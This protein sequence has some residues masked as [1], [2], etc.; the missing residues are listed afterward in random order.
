[1]KLLTTVQ[2]AG[3]AVFLIN[4][5]WYSFTSAPLRS[6]VLSAQNS[7]TW[8][9]ENWMSHET[10]LNHRRQVNRLRDSELHLPCRYAT[11]NVLMHLIHLELHRCRQRNPEER[12]RHGQDNGAEPQYPD[13]S[14]ACLV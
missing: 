7:W 3:P 9:R 14:M 10:G 5:F 6:T 12:H 11:Q 8:R 13:V 1:M 2:K 4:N